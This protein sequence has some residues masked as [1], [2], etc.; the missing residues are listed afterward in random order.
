MQI[1]RKLVR[2]IPLEHLHQDLNQHH[3]AILNIGDDDLKKQIN[4][5]KRFGN[6]VLKNHPKLSSVRGALKTITLEQLNRLKNDSSTV[7][8]SSSPCLDNSLAPQLK[9][10]ERRESSSKEKSNK[11]KNTSDATLIK[12]LGEMVKNIADMSVD[13]LLAR[14]DDFLSLMKGAESAFDQQ[15][16][17]LEKAGNDFAQAS[18]AARAAQRQAD[19]LAEDVK[20]SEA[21]LE[22][23]KETLDELNNEAKGQFPIPDALQAKIDAANSAVSIAS[24]KLSQS[25]DTFDNFTHN[26]LNP[27]LQLE[28]TTKS[29]LLEKMN[30]CDTLI[31]SVSEEQRA[32]V[33]NKRK[34]EDKNAKSLTY[35]MAL[36]AEL[37]NSSTNSQTEAQMELNKKLS[38]AAATDAKNKAVEAAEKQRQAEELM[39]TMGCVGKILN[40]LIVIG[41]FAAAAFTGGASLVLAGAMLAL[42]IADEVDQAVTGNSFISQALKPLMDD[43]IKPMIDALAHAFS[44][45]LQGFGVDKDT[46]DLWGQILGGVAVMALFAVATMCGGGPLS[47]ILGSVV[48]KLGLDVA[49]QVGKTMAQNAIKQVVESIVKNSVTKSIKSMMEK[50][51]KSTLGKI[52]KRLITALGKKFN[53]SESQAATLS[54]N[55]DKAVLGTEFLNTTSQSVTSVIAANQLLEVA[56]LNAKIMQDAAILALLTTMVDMIVDYLIR[57]VEVMA[58]IMSNIAQIANEQA[59]TSK[60]ITRNLAAAAG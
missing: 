29:S 10:P 51:L 54:N 13:K 8:F 37:I 45:V 6:E 36:M 35:L 52:I 23:A 47:R 31:K 58:S 15:A 44:S 14:L 2:P 1:N 3:H 49:L 26:T 43:V 55:V 27:A 17:I 24:S 21:A 33:E 38:E 25:K 34:E 12:L 18:D 22:K 30:D 41:S 39:Q 60:L 56:K 32:A 46:A 59:I 19:Q 42:T 9:S 40:W 20:K 16:T 11:D 7:A 50:L 53:L 28:A 48:K 4:K 57:Q 5:A